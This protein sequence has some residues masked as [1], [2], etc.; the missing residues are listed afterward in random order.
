MDLMIAAQI[1]PHL[2]PLLQS[3]RR[4]KRSATAA[5][6][7]PHVPNV[8]ISKSHQYWHIIPI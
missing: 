4:R 8:S 1:S 6:H 7:L 2:Y 3:R 5:N